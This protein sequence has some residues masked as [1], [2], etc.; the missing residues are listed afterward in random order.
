VTEIAEEGIE[1]VVEIVEPKI[2][3]FH[4]PLWLWG[5]LSTAGIGGFGGIFWDPRP[6]EIERLSNL[7]EE[8]ID[9]FVDTYDA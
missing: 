8:R 9:L 6:K 2:K 4:F 3:A 5:L 1:E 7:K